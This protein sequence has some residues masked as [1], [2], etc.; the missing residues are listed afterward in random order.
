V[1]GYDTARILAD[2]AGE[3]QRTGQNIDTLLQ[4]PEGFYGSGGYFKF[5]KNG[6]SQRGLDLVKVGNQFEV[7]AP[8]LT[9]A[10]LPVPVDLQPAGNPGTWNIR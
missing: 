9:L 2:I 3:K 10:P 5:D 6:I 4:R 7:V 8:A 1:V